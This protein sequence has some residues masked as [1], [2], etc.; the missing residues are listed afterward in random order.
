[1]MWYRGVWYAATEDEINNGARIRKL[2]TANPTKAGNAVYRFY[3]APVLKE[4]TQ[5]KYKTKGYD[6]DEFRFFPACIRYRPG[7]TIGE[8]YLAVMAPLF[9]CGLVKFCGN[10]ADKIEEQLRKFCEKARSGSTKYIIKAH[11]TLGAGELG[12]LPEGCLRDWGA[13]LGIRLLRCGVHRDRDHRY[14]VAHALVQ[15]SLYRKLAAAEAEKFARELFHD[16]DGDVSLSPNN[17]LERFCNECECNVVLLQHTSL[18]TNVTFVGERYDSNIETL[19]ILQT[20]NGRHFEPIISEQPF[21]SQQL[22]R[23]FKAFHPAAHQHCQR[24][25][26]LPVTAQLINAKTG[27]QHGVYIATTPHT[28]RLI[29]VIAKPADTRLDIIEGKLLYRAIE[30]QGLLQDLRRIADF[31]EAYRP[32]KALS[33]N[34]GDVYAVVLQDQRLI[35]PFDSG[36][37]PAIFVGIEIVSNQQLRNPWIG[38]RSAP[39]TTLTSGDEVLEYFEQVLWNIISLTSATGDTKEK[40]NAIS[41]VVERRALIESFIVLPT[42]QQFPPPPVISPTLACAVLTAFIDHHPDPADWLQRLSQSDST[43]SQSDTTPDASLPPKK[44]F[45]GAD[46]YLDWIINGK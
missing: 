6:G 5:S 31:V 36:V 40:I 46:Q 41:D 27:K 13:S 7:K 21:P 9:R 20:D 38:G 37:D 34:D 3:N 33:G 2:R 26:Q 18:N 42:V 29:P 1:M 11:K 43:P 28:S 10:H 19:I 14:A 12:E 15:P 8:R 17:L 32:A 23:L 30:A 45:E 39:R 22:E 4:I 44:I 35:C 25:I 16:L 24:M